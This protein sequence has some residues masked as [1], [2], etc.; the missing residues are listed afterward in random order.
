VNFFW[1]GPTCA[2]Q[3]LFRAYSCT[4]NLVSL[5]TIVL[6]FGSSVLKLASPCLAQDTGK[7]HKQGNDEFAE[8][9]VIVIGNRIRKLPSTLETSMSGL[10]IAWYGS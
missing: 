2:V 8:L 5:F 7:L 4:G 1:V 10:Q 9:T 6:F 3:K